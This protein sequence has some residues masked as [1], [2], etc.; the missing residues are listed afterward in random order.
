VFQPRQF[1]AISVISYFMMMWLTY[2]IR[3]S[4][5][6]PAPFADLIFQKCSGPLSIL[7]ILCEIELSQQSRAPF[8][9]AFC[10]M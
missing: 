4:L 7:T 10:F 2:E 6:S 5:Q 1:F 8:A 9:A 3:L